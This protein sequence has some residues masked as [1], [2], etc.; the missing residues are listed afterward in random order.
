MDIGSIFLILALIIL[1][2]LFVGKPLLDRKASAAP[3]ITAIEDHELSSLLAERDRILGALQELDFDY[4]LGKIPAEDYPEQRATLITEGS[5]I[6]RKLDALQ[7]SDASEDAEARLETAVAARRADAA[8]ANQMAPS[9]G[10]GYKVIPPDDDL[11][12]LIASRKRSRTEKATG[13]C[14]QCGSPLQVADRFCPK[15]GAKIV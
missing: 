7:P 4:A 5:D 3:P 12:T 14:P 6:L 1:V 11:E 15:C 8:L 10:N 2:I 9:G 13:F